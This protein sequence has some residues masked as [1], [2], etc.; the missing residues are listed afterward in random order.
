MNS[1]EAAADYL[2]LNALFALNRSLEIRT[3][4][5]SKSNL[6]SLLTGHPAA[7]T[8]SRSGAID[9]ERLLGEY[10]KH[11]SLFR[12][13]TRSTR[14]RHWRC[15]AQK[16]GNWEFEF[17]EVLDGRG[18]AK[19]V[20]ALVKR[21]SQARSDFPIC[22][23]VPNVDWTSEHDEKFRSILCDV[24]IHSRA[25]EEPVVLEVKDLSEGAAETMGAR[26]EE[27][28]GD[29][30]A[31]VRVRREMLNRVGSFSSEDLAA[32]AESTT[33]NP[34]Q[35]ASDH[36]STGELFGVRFG[37]EWRY[38]KFQFDSERHTLPEV[39]PILKALSPD[40]QGWD[41]LQWFLE[42]HEAL[43]GHTPL[44]VW[45]RNRHKVVEAANTERWD[46]RD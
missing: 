24:F 10:L 8:F 32:A 22:A 12:P 25:S 1:R 4:V 23:L 38:P 2:F 40:D 34:S 39:K 33:S 13:I 19:K 41:R 6:D 43:G 44:E 31:L 36:R 42:P 5:Y 46:G 15:Y 7:I 27:A 20:A 3:A 26:G 14:V 30:E 9:T 29:R 37:R 28:I 16:S 11:D 45:K 21:V 17:K 18:L 35:F